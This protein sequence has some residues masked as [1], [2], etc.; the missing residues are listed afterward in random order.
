[1]PPRTGTALCQA[2]LLVWLLPGAAFASLSDVFKSKQFASLELAPVGAALASTVSSTYP[3]ASASSSVTYVYNPELDTLERRT[4]VAGPIFGER[5]E[6]IGAGEFDLVLSYSYIHLS[7]VNGEDL[8]SLP[9]RA[10]VN[11]RV[12]FFPV[13]GG[14]TLNDGRFTNFLPVQ[15]NVDLDV[16]AHQIAPSLTYGITPDLDVNLVLPLLVTSL[17]VTAH[18]TVPDPRFPEFKLKPGDPRARMQDLTGADTATGI[19]DL[20]LRTKY[21][22]HHG[23]P[24]D[25]AWGLAL[26]LPTGNED[27]F[28]GS[29]TTHVGPTLIFSRIFAE[30]VEPF[31]NLG[32][33]LNTDDVGRSV[34]RWAVGATGQMLNSLTA[35]V[36]FLGRNEFAAQADP[37]PVPFFFQIERNDIYDASIGLRWN[38]TDTGVLS[39]NVLLPLNRDGLRADFIP[40]IEIEYPF[41]VGR[42]R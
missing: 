13:K 21:V 38:F 17:D 34:F 10:R 40:T 26:S 23:K 9:N 7:T 15:A 35:A 2:L 22:I 28:Q 20:L 39:A 1:M 24:F 41:S 42:H 4:G 30:R 3:V 18:T 19:G 16:T 5:A 8:D 33:D 27:N 11:G 36:V 14:L 31:L 12:L 6:T 37:I 25:L 32:V 29:G